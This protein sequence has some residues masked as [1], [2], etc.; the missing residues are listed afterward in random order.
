MLRPEPQSSG[1]PERQKKKIYNLRV[2]YEATTKKRRDRE[3]HAHETKETS[4]TIY[5]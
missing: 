2:N 3:R 4:V 1:A 5:P